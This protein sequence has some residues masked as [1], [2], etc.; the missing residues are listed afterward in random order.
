MINGVDQLI[1]MKSD[2]LDTFDTIKV[3]TG[4]KVNGAETHEVPFDTF[5][6]VE[7]VYKEFK[8]WK[9]FGCHWPD[10]KRYQYN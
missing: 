10:C 5:A 9:R 2:V 1:M 8:G 4:Y 7:P 3:A 6:E